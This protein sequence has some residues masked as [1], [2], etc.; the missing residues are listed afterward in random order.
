MDNSHIKDIYQAFDAKDIHHLKDLLT[1]DVWVRFGNAKSVMGKDHVIDSLTEF[2]AAIGEST[3]NINSIWYN[4]NQVGVEAR[5]AYTRKDHKVVSIPTFAVWKFE[6]AK[7]R[8]IQFFTNLQPVF[9]HTPPSLCDNSGV[10]P[11]DQAGKESFPASDPPSW[12]AGAS[13]MA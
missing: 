11:V 2:F 5:A 12:N 13:H 3:H 6:D 8:H 7:I 9:E 10:D 4:D 1:D